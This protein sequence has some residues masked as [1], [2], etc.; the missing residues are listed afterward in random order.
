[1]SASSPSPTDPRN[2]A[3]TTRP[4]TTIHLT[5][6]PEIPRV[7]GRPIRAE[8]YGSRFPVRFDHRADVPARELAHWGPGTRYMLETFL[9]VLILLVIAIIAIAW[10]LA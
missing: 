3:S 5:E 4:G 8:G 10:Y 6:H 7:K 1:M 2:Q 9:T